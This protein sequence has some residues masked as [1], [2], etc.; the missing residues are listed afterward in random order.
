MYW[1]LLIASALTDK[2][3]VITKLES[4]QQCKDLQLQIGQLIAVAQNENIE[5]NPGT[6][7]WM[8]CRKSVSDGQG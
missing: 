3:V 8:M 2:P 7:P 1:A 6:G 5:L 4:E